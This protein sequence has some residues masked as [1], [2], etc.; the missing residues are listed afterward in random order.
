MRRQAILI[1][2]GVEA[3]GAVGIGITAGQGSLMPPIQLELRQ[4]IQLRLENTA[5]I[6]KVLAYSKGIAS[7]SHIRILVNIHN[8]LYDI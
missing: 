8:I 6:T 5:K 7:F 1:F 2:E 4:S 3:G